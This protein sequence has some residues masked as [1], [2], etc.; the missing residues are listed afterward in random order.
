MVGLGFG[1]NLHEVIRVG[2]SGFLY[3]LLSIS[4]TMLAGMALAALFKVER[5]PAFLISTGTAICGRQRHRR[6]GTHHPRQR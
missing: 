5:R 4:F 2:R 1:M 6:R 3:T